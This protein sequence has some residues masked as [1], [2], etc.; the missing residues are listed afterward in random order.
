MN[1]KSMA[2]QTI[3]TAGN[4]LL[5]LYNSHKFTAKYKSKHQLVTSADLVANKIIAQAIKKHFPNHAILSEETG[6]SKNKSDYLW[7]I[8]PLDGTTNFF[9]H[10]PL[11][12]VSIALAHQGKII[13]G[14]VYAP[15]VNELYVAEPGKGAFLNNKK[16]KVSNRNKI[17]NALLTYCHGT[18]VNSWKKAIKI[19]SYYKLRASF[20]RQLGS[21]SLELCYVASGRTDSILIPG[22]HPWDVAAGVLILREA[23]GK[24][25]DFAGKEWNVKSKDMVASNKRIHQAILKDLKKIK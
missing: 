14:V 16:L 13:L 6:R 3:K 23:G 9:M 4:E 1:H 25:T 10:N 11:F 20:I 24:V 5:K 18:G 22:A 7:I 19:Y 17:S 15:A 2:L 12:A 21:A 8:D